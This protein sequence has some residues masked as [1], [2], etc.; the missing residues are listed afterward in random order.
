MAIY[1]SAGHHNRDSGAIGVGGRQENKETVKLR[2][3]ILKHIKPGHK[4]I[5]DRDEETLAQYLRRIGPGNA[6]VVLEVHFDS[7]NGTASGTTALYMTG[8][9]KNSVTFAD[10]LS[11]TV[12]ATLGITNRGAK[13]ETDSARGRLGLVHKEGITA[14]L[15]ICFIDNPDDMAKYDD[16]WDQVAK[17]IADVLMKFDDIIR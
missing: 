5:T 7:A 17:A 8:A 3:K 13:S 10:Q 4:V 6:S 15:E 9:S 1:L 11:Q 16:H 12:A 2:D 14:L